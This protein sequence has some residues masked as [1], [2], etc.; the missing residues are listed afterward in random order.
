MQ[1]AKPKIGRKAQLAFNKAVAAVFNGIE[2]VSELRERDKV[3]R[4]MTKADWDC[5]YIERVFGLMAK[6]ISNDIHAMTDA[7]AKQAKAD[8]DK[9]QEAIKEETK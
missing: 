9:L 2:N 7:L 4:S 6:A 5:M 3:P 1:K 8:V